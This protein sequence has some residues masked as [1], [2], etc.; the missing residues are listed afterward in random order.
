MPALI[1]NSI[2]EEVEVGVEHMLKLQQ[3][4]K[5]ETGESNTRKSKS[6]ILLKRTGM[7]KKAIIRPIRTK[8]QYTSKLTRPVATYRS[9]QL[10]LM[11]ESKK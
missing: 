11:R 5:V 2:D 6:R 8:I 3:I 1:G 9:E 7:R 10:S 4:G